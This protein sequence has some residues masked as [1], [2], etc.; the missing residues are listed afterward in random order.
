MK[1]LFKWWWGMTV[2][3]L[4][5]SASA[6][7]QETLR[8]TLTEPPD[9]A[10]FVVNWALS[11]GQFTSIDVGRV[12]ESTVIVPDAKVHFYV[13]GYNAGGSGPGS[14]QICRYYGKPCPPD[15]VHAKIAGFS[16][17]NAETDTVVM[18]N[19]ITGHS[20]DFGCH[21]IEIRGNKYL[22]QNKG[23]IR[24][25]FDGQLPAQ[26]A[27]E[28]VYA[29]GWE[30]GDSPGVW[31]C[32]SS[33]NIGMHTLKVEAFDSKDCQGIPY[34][35]Q[36]IIFGVGVV[37]EPDFKFGLVSGILLLAGLGRRRHA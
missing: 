23:S 6:D 34:D 10:G 1:W 14:N 37:P 12:F 9:A 18:G 27:C 32:A 28:N 35:T 8:W 21:A 13:Y 20:F 25:T 31:D 3:L 2:L 30:D 4:A 24:K 26:N 15:P 29:F 17:W 22:Q 11:G 5:L 7:H 16:L 19:F 36:E 33:L